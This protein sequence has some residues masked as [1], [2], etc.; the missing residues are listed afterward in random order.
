MELLRINNLKVQVLKKIIIND[1]S[2]TINEGEVHVIMGRNGSGKSTLVNALMGNEV[3]QVSGGNINFLKKD[4]TG[5]NTDERARMGIYLA[6]QNPPVID[7]LSTAELL[8]NN[9][10]SRTEHFK[11][12]NFIKELETTATSLGINNEMLHRSI[13]DGF[14]GGERKKNEILQLELLKPKLIILDEID[15]GVDIDSLK[16][17]AEVLI[18]YRLE[19]PETAILM[20]THHA[21]FFKYLEPNY[22]H[23]MNNGELVKSGGVELVHQVEKQGFEKTINCLMKDMVND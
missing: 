9:L 13:N 22:V 8:R 16:L 19:N 11:L 18:N 14:S 5:F 17:I 1:L 15:S 10:S 6:M 2:L 12:F 23:I 4:I 21:N 20:I 3:Y 7:G